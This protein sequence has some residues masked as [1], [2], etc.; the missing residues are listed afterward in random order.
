MKIFS[1]L[2][3]GALLWGSVVSGTELPEPWLGKEKLLE[4]TPSYRWMR[5]SSFDANSSVVKQSGTINTLRFNTQVALTGRWQAG[6]DLAAVQSTAK[7][8]RFADIALGG[9]HLILSDLVGDPLSLTANL[10]LLVPNSSLLDDPL[11]FYHG[12][13]EGEASLSV[14]KEISQGK[15]WLYRFWGAGALGASDKGKPWIHWSIAGEVNID[16]YWQAG[17]K[18]NSYQSLSGQAL[19]LMDF[20]SG[21]GKF[22][23]SSGDLVGNL[24]YLQN[25][26]GDFRLQVHYRLW[27]KNGPRKQY[28]ATL[29]YTY[30]LSI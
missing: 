8:V 27:G 30:P 25:Y 13:C 29:A 22:K 16:S 14:G 23:Q 1:K 26:A 6:I 11:H 20:S 4:V 7:G 19:N 17:C 12:R 18:I 21:Y 24:R 10:A 28:G 3:A 5:V 15:Y 9:Q 2:I